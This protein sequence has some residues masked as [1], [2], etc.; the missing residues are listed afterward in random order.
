[1][2]RKRSK[3]F[4]RET[5]KIRNFELILYH[6]SESYDCEQLLALLPQKFEKWAYI[7]HDRDTDN[8]GELKK[9]HYH[10]Y[11]SRSSPVL[12]STISNAFGLAANYINPVLDWNSAIQYCTHINEP[13]KYLYLPSDITSNFDHGKLFKTQRDDAEDA[14]AIFKFICESNCMNFT[15]LTQWVLDHG[16][17]AAFRRGQSIW[18]ELLWE[19]RQRMYSRYSV[20]PDLQLQAVQAANRVIFQDINDNEP[21]PFEQMEF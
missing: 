1:M 5:D 17:W 20:E 21:V 14:A 18:K 3:D 11:G 8:T 9:A 2:A 12:I 13:D 19:N 15:K 6:D 16:Y 7:K 4:N 10:A